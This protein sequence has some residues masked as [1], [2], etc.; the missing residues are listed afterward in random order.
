MI[1]LLF[2]C[3]STYG[4][5]EH[6]S[7]PTANIYSHEND[8]ELTVGATEVF[9]ANIV[10][11]NDPLSSLSI[12]WFYGEDVVCPDTYIDENN[13]TFCELT[14]EEGKDYV[15]VVVRDSSNSVGDDRVD[16]D[17]FQ[18]TL[19]TAPLI[20]VSPEQPTSIDDVT[21]LA[22]AT[23]A[24]GDTLSYVF[25]WHLVDD[26]MNIVST[27]N[28]L[29]SEHTVKG[30][31]WV[32]NAYAE[33]EYGSGPSS[34][35]QIGILNGPPVIDGIEIVPST[36]VY[37]DS[38]LTCTASAEDPDAE[39]EQVFLEYKWMLNGQI[40]GSEQEVTLDPDVVEPTDEVI[41]V[42]TATDTEMAS[43]SSQTSVT[44]DNRA[45]V[46]HG[47]GLTPSSPTVSDT[48]EFWVDVT[49]PDLQ[50]PSVSY[51]WTVNGQSISS[52]TMNLSNQFVKLDT[53][54]VIATITDGVD[55]QQAS[56]STV[57]VNS[58]PT[59]P[60]VVV[61]PST[62]MEGDDLYCDLDVPSTDAD[63]DTINYLVAWTKNGSTYSGPT[64]TTNLPDDTVPGSQVSLNDNW[65]CEIYADDGVDSVNSG[66]QS[67]TTVNG[68][69]TYTVPQTCYNTVST[70]NYGRHSSCGVNG[71]CVWC[72]NQDYIDPDC[73]GWCNT[74]IPGETPCPSWHA[75]YYNECTYTETSQV[76][77]DCSY[78]T[79][80]LC[81]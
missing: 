28:Q 37:N 43:A 72:C 27:S 71:S 34:S 41:C 5:K 44:V 21:A 68:W 74:A 63:G 42:V 80:D 52:N 10:D 73:E 45:F 46:I 62:P 31:T 7:A 57:I 35:L 33:D 36:G 58:I 49:D 8:M 54:E 66:P 20:E 17:L 4:I 79:T 29:S 47:S 12:E 50:E 24:N 1:W 18:N 56:G 40:I 16:F 67:F 77:Y 11:L 51:A 61:S 70:T 32:V 55:T 25:S 3:E 76:P 13:D 30:D 26:E 23:D 53:V 48:L 69:C 65:S 22:T 19:P 59:T 60:T 2:A 38:V 64:S 14:I 6:N 9:L 15:R 81:N 78:T 75:E 39:S